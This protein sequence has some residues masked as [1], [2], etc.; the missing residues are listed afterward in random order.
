[1]NEM[2]I[3]F[4]L[5][6]TLIDTEKYYHIYWPKAAAFYGYEITPEMSLE[7]RSLGRPYAPAK[8]REWFGEDVDYWAIRAKRTELMTPQ[9]E[10]DGIQFKP[11]AIELLQWLKERQIP[12]A[13]ATANSTEKT[14]N[15]L[16][17]L[18]IAQYF[19]HVIC[20]T[21]VEHGKPAP[22]VYEYACRQLGKKPE[23]CFAVEDSPNGVRSAH[24][25]GCKVIMVPDLT[26]PDEELQKLLFARVDVLTEIK[27]LFG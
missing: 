2:T 14:Q 22:D 6:G 20:A 7:L 9:L 17:K 18:N 12:V 24:A 3:I 25:A 8:F 26:Q 4:D 16:Q 10:K 21:E 23:Q 19:D 15:Y 13:M 5:D 27:K 1:M 11:G